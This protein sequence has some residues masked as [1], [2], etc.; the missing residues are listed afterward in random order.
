MDASY[1]DFKSKVLAFF[2]IYSPNTKKD[3]GVKTN[4]SPTGS[5]NNWS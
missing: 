4:C 2:V 1:G 3:A 5:E